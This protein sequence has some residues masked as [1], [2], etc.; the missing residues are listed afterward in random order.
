MIT[1]PHHAHVGA[2][3]APMPRPG[4][5]P[6]DSARCARLARF[7]LAA[8]TRLAAWHWPRLALGAVLAL[9]ALLN[10]WQLD[11]LGYANT[12]YAA[13]VKSM[14]QSWHNFVFVSFDPGGFVSI[15]KPPL[16]FWIETASARLFGFS[17]L[18]LLLPEVLAG[19]LS[20][21]VLYRLVARIWGRG[22]GL[23][24]ALF[25]AVTPVSVVTARNNTIDS[26]LVLTVLLAAWAVA[27]AVETGQLRWLLLCAVLVGLG[28]NIKML[29]AY[30]VVPA[31]G[32][33]YLV[34][35]RASWRKRLGHLD[36]GRI[37]AMP[38]Q[39]LEAVFREKPAIHRF[40]GAMAERVQRL[41]RDIAERF[42]GDGSRVWTE[43]TSG[44]D[45]A[46]RIGSLPGF[47][48]MKVRS[49]TATLV[50][51]FDVKPQGWQEVMPNHPTLGDADSAEALAEY[52]AG[53]RAHKQALRAQQAGND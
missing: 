4:L 42:G 6:S 47:G 11:R 31:F 36:P 28:F 5:R 21:A 48:D 3:A 41:C 29:E 24:A 52:Q 14:L 19:V 30:L 49:L 32:L 20:V 8:F 23:L 33:V 17:G 15:D 34:G 9:A 13:A 35:A 40:P 38:P 46:E 2:P 7:R 25:L 18:S 53:K 10:F 37:A 1:T 26:L 16:G 45:M 27:R 51:Q 50:K 43:A 39:E 12:Y 22:A 44:C